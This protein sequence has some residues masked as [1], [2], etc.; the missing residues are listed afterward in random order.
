MDSLPIA[1]V[2][3]VGASRSLARSALPD[4]PVVPDRPPRQL[5]L[6]RSRRA[7]AAGLRRA[8]DRVAPAPRPSVA[9]R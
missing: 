5:R 3:G 9:A 8:A 6:A 2:I 4:A 7:L 1:A